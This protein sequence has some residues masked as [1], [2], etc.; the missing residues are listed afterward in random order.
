MP[1]WMVKVTRF[2]NQLKISLPAKAIQTLGWKDVAWVTLDDSDG[3]T[4]VVRKFLEGKD[5]KGSVPGYP[6]K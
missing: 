1:R 2:E 4:L 5:L 6:S 3:K